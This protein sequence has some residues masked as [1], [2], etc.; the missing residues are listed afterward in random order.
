M[1][2]HE[3]FS[4]RNEAAGGSERSFGFVFTGFFL[5]VGLVPKLHHR[6]ARLWA[7]AVAGGVLLV[8]LIA[9]ALLRVPNRLWMK[10]GLLLSKIVNPI[11]MGILFYGIVTP[12]A[13][14]RRMSGGDSMKLRF[15]AQA[16]SYWQDRTPPGPAPETMAKQF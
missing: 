10:L 11:V 12:I 8:A 15:D 2:G 16:A 14:I 1:S 4:R 9:P 6:P 5:L 13:W 7:I 3:D